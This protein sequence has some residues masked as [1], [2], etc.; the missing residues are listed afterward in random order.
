MS[1]HTEFIAVIDGDHTFG[2]YALENDDLVEQPIPK[3][4]PEIIDDAFL[5]KHCSSVE[6]A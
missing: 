4:W 5:R 1:T 2:L 3:D 6:Y